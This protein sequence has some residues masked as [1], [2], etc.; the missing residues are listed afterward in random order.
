MCFCTNLQLVG[1]IF[2][3]DKQF[4]PTQNSCNQQ[5]LFNAK[6]YFF[7]DEQILGFGYPHHLTLWVFIPLS[8]S[9]RPRALDIPLYGGFRKWG[10]SE[11]DGL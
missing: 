8:L 1:T 9:Q 2:Y 6:M 7:L 10:Y 4:V 5:Y 11:M 3:L